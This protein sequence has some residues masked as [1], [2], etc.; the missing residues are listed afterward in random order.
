MRPQHRKFRAPGTC[1]TPVCQNTMP[2]EFSYFLRHSEFP[3]NIFRGWAF[4]FSETLWWSSHRRKCGRETAKSHPPNPLLKVE[5]GFSSNKLQHYSCSTMPGIPCR[6]NILKAQDKA[7]ARWKVF[8][9]RGPRNSFSY[10]NKHERQHRQPVQVTWRNMPLY[11]PSW[12][13]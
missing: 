7:K 13:A 12:T 8:S 3:F 2:Q 10:T 6:S 11:R 5:E 9:S 4:R 1:L